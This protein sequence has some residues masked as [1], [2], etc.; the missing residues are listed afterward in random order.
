MYHTNLKEDAVYLKK[1]SKIKSSPQYIQN[2]MQ[3]D[4][5]KKVL[6]EHADVPEKL[7]DWLIQSVEQNATL[8]AGISNK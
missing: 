5:I 1:L 6:V 8:I 3:I 2:Q 4:S 7:L